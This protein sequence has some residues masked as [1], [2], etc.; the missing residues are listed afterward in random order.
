MYIFIYFHMSR[1]RINKITALI[2]NY[3]GLH[4]L[5]NHFETPYVHNDSVT[6]YLTFLSFD[7]SSRVKRELKRE[8]C[9]CFIEWFSFIE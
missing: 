1:K 3:T 4:Q 8:T 2:A 7:L 9:V 5:K 6:K